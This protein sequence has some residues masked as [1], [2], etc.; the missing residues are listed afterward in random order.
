M[1]PNV[2]PIKSIAPLPVAYISAAY[3]SA[4]ALLLG[5]VYAFTDLKPVYAPLGFLIPLLSAKIDFTFGKPESHL[6]LLL[7][8]VIAAVFYAATGWLSGFVCALLYNFMS[9]HFQIRIDG[10]ID[11]QEPPTPT[12]STASM[13]GI[14]F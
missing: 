8:I 14:R 13:P 5:P 10:E 2:R 12:A 4:I 6:G 11:A 3:Y 1:R 7:V 9:K